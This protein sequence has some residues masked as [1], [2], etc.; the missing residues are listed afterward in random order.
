MEINSRL[1]MFREKIGYSQ[2]KFANSLNLPQSTYAQ[3]ELKKRSI[4]DEL[5]QQL[6]NMGVDM[7]WLITGTG[8]MYLPGV[9][10]GQSQ[11]A[12]GS[13]KWGHESPRALAE[14]VPEDSSTPV[15]LL[16]QK[17]SAGPGQIWADESFSGEVIAFPTRMV[18]RYGGY[19]LG[20]AEVRGDS[21]EP[22]LANG[23]VVVFASQMLDGNGIYALAIDGEVFVKR[24]EFDPLEDTIRIISDNHRYEP[25]L[26]SA[27]T[28]RVR[29]LGRIIGRFLVYW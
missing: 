26:L 6:A 9:S 10:G 20:G 16:S 1:R 29:I 12:P 14:I 3:Y 21:M 11:E 22:T 2:A 19:R 25:K 23:D 4:P 27:R 28:E 17:L 13:D 18:K 8:S 7:N 15:P 5:K 24:V